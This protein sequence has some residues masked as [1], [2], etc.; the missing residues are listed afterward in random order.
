MVII[1]TFNASGNSRTPFIINSIGLI[2]NVILDPVFILVLGM[3]V[4]GAAIATVISQVIGCL[5]L[6]IVIGWS[7]DRPFERYGLR[8]LRIEKEKIVSML[9][10]S[11]PIGLEGLLF[12]FLTMITSRIEAS[13]GAD[14]MAA[15]KVGSQIESLSWLIGGGF[16]SALVAV[17]GQNYGAKKLN[18]KHRGVR[19]SAAAMALW[20]LLI[21]AL[22]FFAGGTLFSFFLSE[23]KLVVLGTRYLRIFACCQLV[24]NLE[25]VAAGAFKG[26][27]RTVIPSAVSIVSNVIR[28][29]LALLLSRT[30][31]GLTGV[32]IAVVITTNLRGLSICLWY[33]FSKKEKVPEA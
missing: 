29:A 13:F 9:K 4:Q 12:C 17:I 5:G 31:L 6:I 10:W 2:A 8:T 33:L 11:I 22:L 18:R 16:G 30:S 19:V 26:T 20:G 15:G 32:W 23:P 14:A 27:G 25:A 7:R 21:T 1:G 24:M 28:P 3:G